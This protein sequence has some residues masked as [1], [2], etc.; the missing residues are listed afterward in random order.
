MFHKK[1]QGDS[2]PEEC[3]SRTWKPYVLQF[4]LPSP[5]VAAGGIDPQ[6]NKFEQV[7]SDHH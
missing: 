3:L 1:C 2:I 5:D 4:Q 6:M 7:S